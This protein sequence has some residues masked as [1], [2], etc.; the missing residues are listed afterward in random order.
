MPRI[1]NLV[2]NYKDAPNSNFDGIFFFI[3][4]FKGIESY[5]YK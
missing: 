3:S 1:H 5:F 4:K 2:L